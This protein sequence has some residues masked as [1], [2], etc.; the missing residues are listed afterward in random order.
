MEEDFFYALLT[1]HRIWWV[2][3]DSMAGRFFVNNVV[4]LL[5]PT[6]REP[7]DEEMFFVRNEVCEDELIDS[8]DIDIEPQK[9]GQ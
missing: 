8:N 3:L 9:R 1:I 4:C 2:F 6:T 7:L 5:T